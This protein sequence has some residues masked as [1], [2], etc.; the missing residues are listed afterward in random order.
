MY[1]YVQYEGYIEI[2][3][4]VDSYMYLATLSNRRQCLSTCT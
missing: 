1:M 4:Q 2:N 3:W